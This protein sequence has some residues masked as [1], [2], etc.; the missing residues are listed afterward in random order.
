MVVEPSQPK[1]K[2]RLS[3]KSPEPAPKI[4]LRFGQKS[5]GSTGVAIDSDA[6]KRQQDLVKAGTNGQGAVTT[7]GTPHPG[8]RNP[9]GSSHS[10]SGAAPIP[11]LHRLSQERARS[12]SAEN[13]ASS[14]NGVKSEGTGKSPALSAVQLNRYLD[15]ARQSPNAAASTMPPPS[16]VTPRLPSGSPHPQAT[17]MNTHN[18]NIHAMPFDP[19]WRQPGKGEKRRQWAF[20]TILTSLDASDALITNLSIATHPGLKLEKHFHL[21]IPPSPTTSQQS[22]TITLPKTHYF[23]RITPTIATSLTHRPHRIFVTV[24][25]VRLNPMPQRLEETDQRRPLYE[26]RVVPG[27]NRIE[28]EVVAGPP[29]GAPKVGSGQE[30]EIEKTTVFANVLKD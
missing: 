5:N 9:F 30:I 15:E 7:N 22:V 23:L 12:S 2:L 4:T 6:L 18:S 24:G 20:K 28:V 11:T 21:D 19:R 25:T 17:T 13:P 27:V 8:P 10:G 26:A 29:R 14:M 16:S 1:V 3:A